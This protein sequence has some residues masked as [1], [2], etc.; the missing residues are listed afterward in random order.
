MNGL[1]AMIF[2][3]SKTLWFD[4]TSQVGTNTIFTLG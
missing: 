2:G 3:V 4:S 1:C